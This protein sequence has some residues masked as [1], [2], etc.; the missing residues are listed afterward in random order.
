MK[1]Y[2]NGRYVEMSPEEIAKQQADAENAEREYWLTIPYDEAVDME[3]RKKYPQR[4][5]EA[6]LN[7][8]LADPTNEQYIAE[9]DEL[10]AYRAECKAFVKERKAVM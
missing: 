10:Q 4:A 7:N 9:F 8:Y 5:V 6:I 3:I 1:K 2:I